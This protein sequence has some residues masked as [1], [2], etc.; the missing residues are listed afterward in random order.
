MFK[1]LITLIL[2]AIMGFSIFF[3]F[4]IIMAKK[5]AEKKVRVLSSIAIGILIF[6]IADVFSDASTIL[7]SNSANGGYI[8]SPLYDLVFFVALATGFFVIFIAEGNGKRQS[9]RLRL[10]F[11]I[12]LGI[13][14]QKR[15]RQ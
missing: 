11:F 12:A 5:L 14:F 2:S 15:H 4:P 13:G 10:S 3:T 1:L 9:S 8:S 6:L 7:Y